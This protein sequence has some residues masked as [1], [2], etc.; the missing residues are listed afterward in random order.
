MTISSL[1]LGRRS[2]RSRCA[3][4]PST[5]PAL[6]RIGVDQPAR[7]P[8]ARAS[9]TNGAVSGSVMTSSTTTGSRRCAA[10]P[11]M[12][13][14]SPTSRPSTALVNARGRLGAGGV[15]QHARAVGRRARAAGSR[16]AC[17]ARATRR[18]AAARSASAAAAR[19]RRSARAR[20]CWPSLQRFSRSAIARAV[21]S[22]SSVVAEI[23]SSLTS[24][25]SWSD[26]VAR[27]A[28][29]STQRQ[30]S[31]LPVLS[32]SGAPTKATGSAV[33][34][35]PARRARSRRRARTARRRRASPAVPR[36]RGS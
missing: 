34:R 16:S 23:A 25:V 29:R 15:A 30:P 5:S 26:H 7:R 32:M 36:G 24:S 13:W 22:S 28:C 6:E 3:K 33:G 1:G 18:R 8:W 21:R 4:V 19:A 27:R 10:V 12:P 17:R 35:P 2:G 11:Q 20:A 9:S 31:T 14:P